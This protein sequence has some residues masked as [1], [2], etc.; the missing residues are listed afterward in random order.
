VIVLV[1]FGYLIYSKLKGGDNKFKNMFS[2][3]GFG[4]GKNFE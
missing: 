3:V 2:K 1:G 4:G